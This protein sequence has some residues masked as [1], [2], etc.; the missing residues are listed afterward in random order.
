LI[1][2]SDNYRI[3]ELSFKQVYATLET[4]YP[5][6]NIEGAVIVGKKIRLFQRGNGKLH[7]NAI[8]DLNLNE[9]LK[10]RVFD[11]THKQI[12]LGRLQNIPLSF[13]D[14]TIANNLCWYLAVAENTESTYLDGEFV[15]AIMGKM[16][17]AG[18]LLEQYPLN[19]LSKP[20]GIVIEGNQIYIITDDDD[21]MKP[22]GLFQGNLP[23]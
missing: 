14:A 7:Q 11:L 19:I 12:D 17:L 3:Q 5:E 18:T 21:R 15:G 9:F 4:I 13:T 6:L 2:V 16:D 23:C 8:I 1:D 22:S 10:D 20:E